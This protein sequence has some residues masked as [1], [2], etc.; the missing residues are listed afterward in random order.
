MLVRRP[1]QPSVAQQRGKQ[2]KAAMVSEGSLQKDV[3]C[4]RPARRPLLELWLPADPQAVP[5]AR[6]QVSKICSQAGIS[7]DDCFALDVA[8]GEALANAVV[9]GA[10]RFGEQPQ[11]NHVCLCVWNFHDRLIFGGP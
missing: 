4:G 10:P 1:S 6:H 11:E 3:R 9:H 2:N 8:L 7:D 5:A